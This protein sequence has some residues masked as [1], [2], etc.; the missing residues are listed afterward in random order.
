MSWSDENT[1]TSNTTPINTTQ[2]ATSR[3]VSQAAPPPLRRRRSR[4]QETSAPTTAESACSSSVSKE[5]SSSIHDKTKTE[6]KSVVEESI[7]SKEDSSP[8]PET[9]NTT[10]VPEQNPATDGTGYDL[11]DD[12]Q[13]TKSSEPTP[14]PK[15]SIPDE[16]AEAKESI[17]I[18]K[19]PIPTKLNDKSEDVTESDENTPTKL[20]IGGELT[21]PVHESDLC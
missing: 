12:D 15:S 2:E 4:S 13:V 10:G 7:P 18:L 8:I 6:H 20:N 5:E 21:Q 16:T 1:P 19:N 3:P 17:P 14:D 11:P 9:V